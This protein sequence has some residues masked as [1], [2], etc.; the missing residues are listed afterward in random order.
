MA[1]ALGLKPI[2]IDEFLGSEKI[3][4]LFNFNKRLYQDYLRK[5]LTNRKDKK[6]NFEIIT[7]LI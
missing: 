5:F 3:P 4:E 2:N 7:K 6:M 1:A